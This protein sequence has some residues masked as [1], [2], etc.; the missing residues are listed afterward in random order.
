M[1]EHD[2]PPFW[3]RRLGKVLR[4]LRESARISPSEACTRLDFSPARLSRME[5]GQTAPEPVVLKAMLDVYGVPASDWTWYLDLGREAR[6]KG[7]WQAYG[8]SAMG[9]VALEEAASSVRDFGL[10]YIPGL[11][12]TEDYVRAVLR[13]SPARFTKVRF[14]NEVDVRLIRQRRLVSDADALDLTAFVDEGALR[15][16]VGG[17]QV[18]RTQLH[19]LV[20]RAELPNV[21][22]RVVPTAVGQHAGM[23]SAFTVL[24]FP[25]LQD[26]DIAYVEHAAG[27][28]FL[29]KADEVRACTLRFDR[30]DALALPV[31]ES[32]ELIER[33][34]AEGST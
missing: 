20:A 23:M 9:Y 7:W 27:S 13:D 5:S 16:P 12:Q 4:E 11:L 24:S 21:T 2:S 8:L 22:L 33:I 17:P 1:G 18:M 15:R 25:S 34:A 31:D 3:R 14:E 19:W 6:K 32:V 29:E 30:L 26:P 28:V 10:A